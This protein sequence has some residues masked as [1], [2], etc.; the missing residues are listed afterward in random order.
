[1]PCYFGRRRDGDVVGANRAVIFLLT[2]K[3]R[4]SSRPMTLS[5]SSRSRIIFSAMGSLDAT[6]PFL[7]FQVEG[8]DLIVKLE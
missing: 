2:V 5:L 6:F 8:I 3:G 4:S 7:S 1:M